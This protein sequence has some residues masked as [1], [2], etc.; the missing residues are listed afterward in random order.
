VKRGAAVLSLLIVSLLTQVSPGSAA[1]VRLPK[2]AADWARFTNVEKQ[3]AYAHEAAE[4]ARL[5]ASGSLKWQSTEPSQ[6]VPVAAASASASSAAAIT[7]TAN[8]WCG[9]NYVGLPDGTWTSA[10]ATTTASEAMWVDTGYYQNQH[11]RFYRG[12]SLLDTFYAADSSDTYVY[13]SSDT[14]FKW[15]FEQVRYTVESWHSAGVYGGPWVLGPKAF[16]TS[17]FMP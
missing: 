14:N 12:T 2:D 6:A 15:W 17:N 8:G 13:A 7:G 10:A 4:F 9:F 16:C 5:N 1:G 3:A 11:D